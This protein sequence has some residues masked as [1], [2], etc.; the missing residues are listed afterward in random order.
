MKNKVAPKQV[1]NTP[2]QTIREAVNS[3]GLSERY[4]RKL[5][6]EGKLPHVMS[7][8]RVIVNVPKLL[9]VMNQMCSISQD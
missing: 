6:A 9:E 2:F 1:L 7:G 3:T 4:L 5:H 8:S